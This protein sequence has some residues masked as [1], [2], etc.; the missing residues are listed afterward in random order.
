MCIASV[1]NQQVLPARI[2]L[3]F[4]G[5]LP[6]FGSFYLEQLSCLAKMLNV[7]WDMTI[8]T[9]KGVRH[10]R[11]WHIENCPTQHLWMGDEDV[12]YP[13]HCLMEYSRMFQQLDLT[14]AKIG[15]CAGV[16][17]D[18]SNRRG[19]ADWNVGVYDTFPAV[20][21][22]A[23]LN[24]FYG[25][26]VYQQSQWFQTVHEPF[27]YLD[28]GNCLINTETVKRAGIKF[29]AFPDSV[30]N[31]GGEDEVFAI[32]LVKHGL[33]VAPC[34]HA[35][36]YHLEKP[37]VMFDETAARKELVIRSKQLINGEKI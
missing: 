20:P 12:I 16:K 30:P 6:H 28:T 24:H 14:G 9:S 19:Y 25:V 33:V 27:A 3:R 17:V 31:A 22:P 2:Q 36:A 4:E 26:M 18:V 10:A 15:A 29:Q 5:K 37:K 8:D 7:E 32:S 35:E 1:L 21:G 11:D 34:L 13:P 23:C